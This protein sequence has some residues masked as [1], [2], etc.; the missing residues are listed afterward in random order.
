[1]AGSN[2]ELRSMSPSNY[3]GTKGNGC[4]LTKT[5]SEDNIEQFAD[6]L[7]TKLVAQRMGDVGRRKLP[8]IKIPQY[9]VRILSLLTLGRKHFKQDVNTSCFWSV[10]LKIICVYF[11]TF[12]VICNYRNNLSA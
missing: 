4:Q 10:Y 7:A 8:K 11:S 3:I 2:R 5:H 9:Q 12:S 1:M 6:M